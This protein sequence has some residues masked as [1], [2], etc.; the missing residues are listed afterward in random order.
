[1]KTGD[2]INE[3]KEILIAALAL[4]AALWVKRQVEKLGQ[5]RWFN[6]DLL[7]G[8]QPTTTSSATAAAETDASK[9]RSGSGNV[10]LAGY[11]RL[12]YRSALKTRDGHMLYDHDEILNPCHVGPCPLLRKDMDC[13]E[14]VWLVDAGSYH[15]GPKCAALVKLED[16]P[17]EYHLSLTDTKRALENSI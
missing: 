14:C 17:T 5:T 12:Y 16:S 10:Y 13:E 11:G 3:G 9:V 1:M 8:A 4:T 7:K 15:Y 2:I 6:K